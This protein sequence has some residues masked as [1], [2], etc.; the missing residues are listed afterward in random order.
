MN[1]IRL[2]RRDKFKSMIPVRK[3]E[4]ITETTALKKSHPEDARKE[5]QTH[6]H[7]PITTKVILIITS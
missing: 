5:V 2:S 4:M 7:T 3:R 1:R 6:V